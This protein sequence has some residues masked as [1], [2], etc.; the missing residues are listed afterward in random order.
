MF[1]GAMVAGPVY[2]GRRRR[3]RWWSR[4]RGCRATP[5]PRCPAWKHPPARQPAHVNYA[6]LLELAWTDACQTGPHV[7][8]HG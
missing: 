5:S 8:T 6:P 2:R 7:H 4:C 1:M 3:C